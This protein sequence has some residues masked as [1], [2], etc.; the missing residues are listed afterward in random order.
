MVVIWNPVPIEIAES[1]M[2]ARVEAMTFRGRSPFATESIE[3]LSSI[4]KAILESSEGRKHPQYV[5]LGYWLRRSALTR[6]ASQLQDRLA[7]KNSVL[8]S[9]GI[10][11]HLPPTN[12]DTIF[13]Y[14]WAVSVLAGNCNIVRLP[15][16]LASNTEWLVKLVASVID[17][18]GEQERQ[19]FCSYPHTGQFNDTLSASCDLRLIWGGDEKT[20]TVSQTPIRPDG[21]SLGFPDRKSFALID[22]H[23]YRTATEAE[24]ETLAVGLFSDVY[25]FDQMGCGSPR[26]LFWIGEPQDLADDLY[27]R[28]VSQVE[29]RNHH[30]EVGVAITK[31]AHLNSALVSGH[32][33]RAQRLGNALAIYDTVEPMKA[34]DVPF[35]GGLLAQMTLDHVS[36][37]RP[38]VDRRTQTI[39]YFGFDPES[40]TELSA[41][42]SGRGGYRIVPVGQALQFDIVWDGIELM[43]HMTRRLVVV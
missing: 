21:L 36:D 24:R 32:A 43:S 17:E 9:R 37:I 15:S 22:T 29:T 12:V 18:K 27:R 10:A 3:L 35:G 5:A 8:V 31:F 4:S 1:D 13:V 20:K 19:C 23:A 14:S 11:L 34:V 2:L 25:W 33:K 6:M 28:L 38:Y 30:I 26:V 40:L 42:I 7:C 41:T 16:D 39:S